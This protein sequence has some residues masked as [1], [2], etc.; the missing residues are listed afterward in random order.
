MADPKLTPSRELSTDERFR[1]GECPVCH[2]HE[3][4]VEGD[5]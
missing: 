2:A 4:S 1:W 5:P 3:N